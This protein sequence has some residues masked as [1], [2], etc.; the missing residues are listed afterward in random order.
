V[1]VETWNLLEDLFQRFPILRAEPVPGTEVH[2][3]SA[4]LGLVFP[5]DYSQF[6][7][8]F[9]AAM[10]GAYPIFGLRPVDPMGTFWS[11]VQVNKHF[12]SQSWP[13]IADWL[14]ISMD[15]GGNPLGIDNSGKVLCSDHGDVISIAENFEDFLRVHCLAQV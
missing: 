14:I 5:D 1:K 9:G 2:E 11:V 8:R 3:A 4:E 15:Q 10:V 7:E 6:V 13:G 12:R